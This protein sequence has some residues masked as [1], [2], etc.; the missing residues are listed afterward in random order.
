MATLCSSEMLCYIQLYWRIT[1]GFL[2][3]DS[4]VVVC[5]IATEEN[6]QASSCKE[7]TH[8]PDCHAVEIRLAWMANDLSKQAVAWNIANNLC[9]C[10]IFL[11]ADLRFDTISKA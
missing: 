2:R 7:E 1:Q 8:L 11:P 10:T 4:S 9:R 5:H 6:E 3:A